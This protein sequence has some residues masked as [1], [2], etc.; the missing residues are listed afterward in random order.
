MRKL[1]LIIAAALIFQFIFPASYAGIPEVNPVRKLMRGIGN[2]T[3][4]GGDFGRQPMMTNKEEGDVSGVTWGVAKGVGFTFGRAILGT[5]ETVTFLIPPYR[6]L[7]EP[8]F[9]FS[10]KEE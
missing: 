6:T 8:E 1:K 3:L 5:Y 9:I 2:M 7:V 4:C 10:D